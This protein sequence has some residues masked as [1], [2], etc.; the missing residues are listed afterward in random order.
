MW[1]PPYQWIHNHHHTNLYRDRETMPKIVKPNRNQL[2]AINH[3]SLSKL[4]MGI[5]WKQNFGIYSI[6]L[7]LQLTYLI[8][9]LEWIWSRCGQTRSEILCRGEEIMVWLFLSHHGTTIHVSIRC[10]DLDTRGSW[11]IGTPSI[12]CHAW[13]EPR[14]WQRLMMYTDHNGEC[15]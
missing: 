13:S 7:S 3:S 12:H 8:Y 5:W 2:L 9:K 4:Q 15:H 6:N 11:S 1:I 10:T 14:K